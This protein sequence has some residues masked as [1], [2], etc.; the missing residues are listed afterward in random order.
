MHIL[1]FPP[2]IFFSAIEKSYNDLI[3][4]YVSGLY[5][6]DHWKINLII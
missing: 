3:I 6:N 1:C 5:K 2:P 4:F